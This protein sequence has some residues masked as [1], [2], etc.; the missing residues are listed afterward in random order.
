MSTLIPLPSMSTDEPPQ[1]ASPANLD[2]PD[3]AA[4]EKLEV[5]LIEASDAAGVT[6]T[7]E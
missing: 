1:Q 3:P 6:F 4:K 5:S 2:S 7:P